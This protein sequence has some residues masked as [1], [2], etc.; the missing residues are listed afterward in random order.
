MG[1]T[2]PRRDEGAEEGHE[3]LERQREERI[4]AAREAHRGAP[5]HHL[6]GAQILGAAPGNTIRGDSLQSPA[7]RTALSAPRLRKQILQG[8]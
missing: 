8:F 4:G 3:D 6:E 1:P 5:E 2:F 7:G